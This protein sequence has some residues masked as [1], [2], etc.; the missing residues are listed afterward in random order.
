MRTMGMSVNETPATTCVCISNCMY[1]YDEIR[2]LLTIFFVQCYHLINCAIESSVSGAA[3]VAVTSGASVHANTQVN[4]NNR[5][6][7]RNMFNRIR[8]DRVIYICAH[9]WDW[10]GFG[11]VVGYL[12]I[13]RCTLM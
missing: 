1:I 6:F 4:N 11:L 13:V 5:K 2:K 8:N 9:K 10:V 12:Q 7:V 3:A